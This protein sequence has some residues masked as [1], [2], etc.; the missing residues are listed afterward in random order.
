M[1]IHSLLYRVSSVSSV[2]TTYNIIIEIPVVSAEE[3]KV[4]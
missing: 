2:T 3:R 1:S 4:G